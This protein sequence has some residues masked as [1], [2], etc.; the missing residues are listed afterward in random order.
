MRT[1]ATNCDCFECAQDPYIQ[2]LNTKAAFAIGPNHFA[3]DFSVEWNTEPILA[4]P[5]TFWSDWWS[6]K[7]WVDWHKKVKEKYGQQRANEVL[8][9]WWEKA[10]FASPTTDF[11]SF[12]DAFRAYAKK[13]GFYDALFSGLGG[14]IGKTASAGNQVIEGAGNVVGATGDAV[15]S[16]GE[17][18]AF[19]MKNV[20]YVLLFVA[21]AAVIY[22]VL[23]FKKYSA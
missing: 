16:L 17:I 7:T 15:E 5:L 1:H 12:D 8:I 22:F 21:I 20:K 2:K 10:P 14:L 4:N 23:Q 18:S 13:E 9:T 3:K 11:R 19:L 6:A